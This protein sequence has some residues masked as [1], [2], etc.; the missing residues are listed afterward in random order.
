MGTAKDSSND[1]KSVV[2]RREREHI[3]HELEK[4]L[5]LIQKKG[6]SG[7]SFDQLLR[8]PQLYRATLSSL[9]VARSISLDKALLDYLES[10][11]KRAFLEVY[12]VKS[13]PLK[14]VKTFF[15]YYFPQSVRRAKYYLL[16]AFGV[17]VFGYLTGLFISL[18]Q[19]SM[20]N[21]FIESTYSNFINPL[22]LNEIFND[23]FQK[24]DKTFSINASFF[25]HMFIICTACL[26]A[27]YALGIPTLFFI[28]VEGASLG[29]STIMLER[30]NIGG[31]LY[32]WYFT[33]YLGCA[34]LPLFI[35]YAASFVIAN[36]FYRRGYYP[37]LVSLKE[38]GKWAGILLLGAL[39]ILVVNFM[40]SELLKFWAN[41][42]S[43]FVV[44]M[45]SFALWMV[46]FVFSGRKNK[47]KILL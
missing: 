20:F 27:G 34:Q 39:F 19:P 15:I 17:F 9:S 33:S 28:F 1:I 42:N 30:G 26:L 4:L 31:V 7:L 47:N 10:L 46:Y 6:F 21:D 11:S 22:S 41:N 16:F 12:R 5:Q 35:S 18:R 2:F 36:S 3:W 43:S 14:I 23:T 38:N 45:L 24:L 44:T 40:L 32:N 37:I 29:G 8:F 13:R 25:I